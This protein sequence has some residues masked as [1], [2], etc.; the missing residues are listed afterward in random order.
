MKIEEILLGDNL[1]MNKQAGRT[2]SRPN[3]LWM[4]RI[5]ITVFGALMCA[6]AYYFGHESNFYAMKK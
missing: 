2:L 6:G 3:R 1:K 5:L 4:K